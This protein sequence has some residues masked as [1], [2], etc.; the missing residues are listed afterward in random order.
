MAQKSPLSP[1]FGARMCPLSALPGRRLPSVCAPAAR[2]RLRARNDNK[3][4]PLTADPIPGG[5]DTSR[6]FRWKQPGA[7]HKIHNSRAGSRG[8]V[9]RA[10]AEKLRVKME[11]ILSDRI[12]AAGAPPLPPLQPETQRLCA[13]DCVTS[14]C[15]RACLRVK[16]GD[17]YTRRCARALAGGR[18]LIHT[19]AHAGGYSKRH[20]PE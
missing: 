8:H 13:S 9:R 12:R 1:R 14:A 15:V 17:T 18:A 19:R 20:F 11:R 2:L 16:S 4:T 10:E 5:L 7:C 6:V 3:Q